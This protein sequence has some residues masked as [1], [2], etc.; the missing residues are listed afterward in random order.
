MHLLA[1]RPG[2]V[3]F[4]ISSS[5]TWQTGPKVRVT[6]VPLF[7]PRDLQ[8]CIQPWWNHPKRAMQT[9]PVELSVH[10]LQVLPIWSGSD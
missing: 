4:W 3:L 5:S 2:F 6:W 9:R 1:K 8:Q 7:L 10:P